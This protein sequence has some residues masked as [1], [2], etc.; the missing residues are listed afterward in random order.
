MFMFFCALS[1][2]A[3]KVQSSNNTNIDIPRTNGEIN[4]DAQLDE[5]Q[6]QH[7]KRVTMNIVTRPYD[8][9]KSP[10]DTQALLMEDGETLFIAFIAQDPNP[11]QIR[12]FLK[13]RDRSWGDDLV[14]VKLDTYND[15]RTAYRFLVNPL[16]SQIDGIESEVTKRESDS[17]DGIWQSAG[18]L[19]EQ[20]YV[21]EIALPLRMLNFNENKQIQDW[22]IELLRFYPRSQSYRISNIPLDR[23]N[24]CELCQ[25]ATARGFSGAKQGNNLTITPAL[26]TTATQ[27][28]DD[29]GEWQKETD[30]E[31]SLDI[32]WGITPDL[33]LNATINPDFSTVETDSARLNINNNFALFF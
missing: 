30:V 28:R 2:A 18:T 9:T 25:L 12:A 27:E 26:V 5:P 15:Q 13:D 19:T 31:P 22:G 32:R 23:G 16:G 24:S 8:N 6:W 17:W 4:I 11:E 21:V 1:Q 14:G 3:D 20:G 7:A 29:D 33:L 10:V